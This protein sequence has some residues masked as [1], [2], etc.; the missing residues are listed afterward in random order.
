[1]TVATGENRWEIDGRSRRR[2]VPTL[3]GCSQAEQDTDTLAECDRLA[4]ERFQ[5]LD[6]M[7]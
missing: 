4:L 7:E 2:Q 3:T 6:A 1:M 5:M